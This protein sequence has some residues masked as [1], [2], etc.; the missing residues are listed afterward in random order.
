[1]DKVPGKHVGPIHLVTGRGTLAVRLLLPSAA[2]MR[3]ALSVWTGRRYTESVQP[4]A[5]TSTYGS[6]AGSFLCSRAGQS[7][8]G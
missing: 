2:L 1:M 4:E 5:S 3:P 6:L 7:D 8:D